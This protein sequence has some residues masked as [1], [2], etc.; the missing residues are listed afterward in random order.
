MVTNELIVYMKARIAAGAG[1][2]EITTA[3]KEGGWTEE[4]IAMAFHEI[5]SLSQ[6]PVSTHIKSTDRNSV[7]VKDQINP[8]W[9][10][11]KKRNRRMLILGWI[12]CA[13]SMMF[14]LNGW[15]MIGLDGLLS[16]VWLGLFVWLV[17]GIILLFTVFVW[18]ENKYLAKTYDHTLSK[19]DKMF[20]YVI[21]F[22]NFVFVL[23]LIP[24]IQVIGFVVLV[25][26]G[27]LLLIVYIMLLL[28]RSKSIVQN[29]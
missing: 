6:P 21:R 17:C 16:E 5:T 18:F 15:T 9:M 22:R 23:S 13:V 26:G 8:V 24:F 10:K 7:S 25:Y 2:N 12:L 11:I 3:L 14:I 20:S 27:W 19:S 1:R 28:R 29:I 4:Q